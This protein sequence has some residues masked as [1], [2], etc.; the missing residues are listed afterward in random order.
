MAGE[1]AK[2]CALPLAVMLYFSSKFNI[3]YFLI[4]IILLIYKGVRY[5]YPEQ[6]HG[7]TDGGAGSWM[8]GVACTDCCCRPLRQ[9]HRLPPPPNRRH[10]SCSFCCP[11][12]RSFYSRQSLLLF[13]PPALP[14]PPP[15]HVAISV[16]V[17]CFQP[18]TSLLLLRPPPLSHPP[19][20]LKV[21]AWEIV[22][23]FMYLPI[24]MPRIMIAT[25]GVRVEQPFPIFISTIIAGIIAVLHVYYLYLQT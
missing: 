6:V 19:P 25:K 21:F 8:G 18:R 9:Y 11:F 14:P 15:P 5:Q 24:D 22:F 17:P 7:R 3:I 13:P 16:P 1:P 12:S 23:M 20:L 2:S 10:Q 4:E